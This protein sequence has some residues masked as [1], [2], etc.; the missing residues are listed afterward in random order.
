[1][2]LTLT[3]LLVLLLFGGTGCSDEQGDAS[4]AQPEQAE[5]TEERAPQRSPQLR[6]PT[7]GRSVEQRLEDAS[8]GAR[9]QLALADVN[10]L[11]GYAFD[12]EVNGS[13]V[14][15]RGDVR[16]RDAYQRAAEVARDVDGVGEVVNELTVGGE[17]VATAEPEPEPT[18]DTST[19]SAQRA[20]DQAPDDT[21]ASEA[22]ANAADAEQEQ[23]Q[24][25]AVYHT[26]RSGQS[27]W[28]IARQYDVSISQIR[29]LNDLS[30]S[31]IQPGD[32]LRIK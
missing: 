29:R 27:L 2:R 31:N 4:S 23:E 22:S 12:A 19:A 1:M 7:D 32:R 17:E 15:L 21:S 3:G 24:D 9:V 28:I 20:E 25:E 6:T 5:A 18:P 26:V 30:G 11:S 13:R 10:S 8:L 16:S 14:V